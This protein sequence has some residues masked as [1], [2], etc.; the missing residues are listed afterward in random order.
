MR[1]I[2]YVVRNPLRQSP[3]GDRLRTTILCANNVRAESKHR[4]TRIDMNF[5]LRN[6][7]TAL[8]IIASLFTLSACGGGGT[9]KSSDAA[10]VS[11][12]GSGSSSSPGTTSAAGSSSS[13]GTTSTT[14][15][16][17]TPPTLNGETNRANNSTFVL[18]ES[19][20]LSF[21]A[22]GL[23]ASKATSLAVK[24]SDEFGNEISSTSLSMTADSYGK[25]SAAF[26]APASKFG[27]YRVEATLPDGTTLA[28]LGTRPAGFITYAV[29]P[30]P[31]SRI[32][33]GDAGS[34]FGMQGGFSYAQGS[35]IQYLGIRYLLDGPGWSELEPNYAGQF[36]EAR[37]AALA[38]GQKYP[39]SVANNSAV[40]STYAIP[41]LSVATVPAW[42]MEPGTGTKSWPAMGVLN[43][44]GVEGFP[45]FAT[46][47]ASQIAAD[48]ASQS[49]HY[50]QVTWEP[51]MPLNFGGTPEQL[52]QYYQL[53]YEAIHRADPKAI[54]MGPTMFPGDKTPMSQLWSAGLASYLDA[55]AMH[56]YVKWPPET[57]G[58]VSNIRLQMQMARSAKGH[59]VTFVG[60]EHGY[61]SGSIGELNEALGDVRATIILLGE[62]FKFDF[63]FYIADFWNQSPS[64]TGSTFG[65][66]W[67]LDP[68][69]IYGTD[70]LGPKPVAPAF[71]A[72]TYWLDGTTTS[73]P[74]SNLSG[75]QMG[76]R[77]Q[78]NGTTI[79]AIWDYQA[80]SSVSLPMPSE[81][82]KIC[83]WMGNCRT[84]TSSSGSLKLSL[85]PSPTYVIGQGL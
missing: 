50:Y 1:R 65:Y 82:V 19:V 68:K 29:V 3:Q 24:V 12:P 47:R 66:Y 76:Y 78:R 36:A 44:S 17:A 81:S 59:S 57:N 11:A 62:G 13:P 48:Y 45:A 54:V 6:R 38:R 46:A 55:V 43:T 42:A 84:A 32:N 27:Y 26:A 8:T 25:A 83:G 15:P 49:A 51:E 72:M 79:L 69:I 85:G 10:Q 64:E 20:E 30:D 16:S 70:K 52:V 33:Y 35:V 40:W 2:G 39:V 67:N 60:T 7:A 80:G 9:T 18:G 28:S 5:D 34:R 37:S 56:P 73:G 74:L 75:T 63:A 41:L 4:N 14:G 21:Q 58:L 61:A 31:A 53:S 71:A 22:S 77:F 23:P